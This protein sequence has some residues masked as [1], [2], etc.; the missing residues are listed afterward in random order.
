[1]VNRLILRGAQYYLENE[2]GLLEAIS[3]D[4]AEQLI[5]T[6]S[7]VVSALTPGLTLLV[8][9]LGSAVIKGLQSGYTY[10]RNQ[11]RGKEDEAVTAIVLTAIT[12]GSVVYVFRTM[13]SGE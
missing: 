1:M 4:I 6:G 8:E 11:I 5:E 12:V 3:T 7:E 2:D 13:R 9:S 10:A